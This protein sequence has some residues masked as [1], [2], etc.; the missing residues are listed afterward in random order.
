[1]FLQIGDG[2]DDET[3]QHHLHAHDYSLWVEE[4]I[5]DHQLADQLRSIEDQELQT[6]E[7]RKRIT[8]A[9]RSKYTAPK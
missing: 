9:I 5:K 4:A 1:M 7:S 6:N 2:V 8:K 3:W